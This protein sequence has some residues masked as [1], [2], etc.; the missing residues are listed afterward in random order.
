VKTRGGEAPPER[1]SSVVPLNALTVTVLPRQ[2]LVSRF[3]RTIVETAKK[4][5]ALLPWVLPVI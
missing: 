2:A 5:L 3:D 4:L 1:S